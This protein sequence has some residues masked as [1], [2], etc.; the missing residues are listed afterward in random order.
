M[1]KY[2]ISGLLLFA[3]FVQVAPFAYADDDV[4]G[5]G[6]LNCIPITVKLGRAAG[7]NRTP[8][9][10]SN[11]NG[12]VSILQDF[13]QSKGYLNSEPTGYFGLLTFQAVKSF[14]TAN[15]LTADGSVGPITR[16]KINALMC[17]GPNITPVTPGCPIGAVYSSVTGQR[18]DGTGNT[19]PS[20]C[21][22]TSGFSTTTGLR[23]DGTTTTTFPPGCNSTSG[24][25]STTGE[26]CDGATN[27]SAKFK[28]GDKVQALHALDVKSEPDNGMSPIGVHNAGDKGVVING[29]GTV[30]PW[31]KIDFD[32]G[33]DGWVVESLLAKVV[34][35]TIQAPATPT[36][37]TLTWVPK[38]SNGN[39]INLMK[40]GYVLDST[41]PY[42]RVCRRTTESVWT[43]VC[44]DATNTSNGVN[45]GNWDDFSMY[46][47]LKLADKLAAN[48]NGVYVE[49]IINSK[50]AAGVLSG[51][52]AYQKVLVKAD[53]VTTQPLT[54]TTPSILPNAKVGQPYSVALNVS[55]GTSS[56]YKWTYTGVGGFPVPGLGASLTYG[57]P[58][59]I[60]GTPLKIYNNG[61]EVTTPQAFTF[62]Y[63]VTSGSQ[64]VSKTFTLT[65][66]PATSTTQP[67]VTVTSPNGG[68]TW[69]RGTIKPITWQYTGT[70]FS[71][72]EIRITPNGQSYYYTI[73]E[74]NQDVSS[75][76]WT[77]GTR[78][79]GVT[80]PDGL[81]KITVCDAQERCDS[82]NSSFTVSSTAVV[83]KF[84]VSGRILQSNGTPAVASVSVGG[85][86]VGT[87]TG[88]SSAIDGRYSITDIPV[89][90]PGVVVDGNSITAKVDIE[91]TGT[92]IKSTWYVGVSAGNNTEFGDW[93]MPASGTVLGAST[94]FIPGCFSGAL[95]SVTTGKSCM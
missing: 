53:T 51:G 59:Y 90:A 69:V 84:S 95:Y 36:S 17:G 61:I 24:Y 83:Q 20:G 71:P 25:S 16:A 23:C 79:G 72:K 10:D 15:G 4:P 44:K 12:E 41:V 58:N 74:I 75:Y 3:M 18:C 43:Y 80:L 93:K 77:V 9:R 48:P 89:N 57:N 33:V 68:E 50:N 8:S 67:T 94:S 27:S 26:K 78:E 28:I 73:A 45:P 38:Q 91:L 37:P 13:L 60:T 49:Y 85:K 30:T 1:K 14:Q 29:G 47:D 42:I 6:T 56:D 55:G 5:D 70:S 32:S 2:I 19:F 40:V 76:N 62:S 7:P 35:T 39:V 82:S 81:Y 22:S 88:I 46:A 63:N 86:S 64:S 21:S 54:I 87:V 34:E 66:D 52:Y 92:N 65:V 11:S 31:W